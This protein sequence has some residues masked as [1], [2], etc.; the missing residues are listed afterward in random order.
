MILYG[1]WKTEKTLNIAFELLTQAKDLYDK[2]NNSK[3]IIEDITK[4]EVERNWQTV[5]DALV[6]KVKKT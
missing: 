2:C 1:N 3:R 4:E 6:R 5:N